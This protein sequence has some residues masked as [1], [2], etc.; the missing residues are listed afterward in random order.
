MEELSKSVFALVAAAVSVWTFL[1]PDAPGFASPEFARI[2]F[3]HFPCPIMLTG[4]IFTAVWFSYR[5]VVGPSHRLRHLSEGMSGAAG[6]FVRLLSGVD[7][8]AREVWDLRAIAAIELGLVFSVL[9]MFSGIL[10][11]KIQW[12]AWWNWDPRQ[13]SFLISMLFYGAYFAIRAAFPD[14]EKRAANSAAY[15]MATLPAQLFL[16]FVYPRIKESL[17]PSNTIMGGQLHGGYLWAMLS[18]MAVVGVLTVWLY[19]L[20]VRAGLLLLRESDDRLESLENPRRPA[21]GGVV[22][23]PVPVPAEGGA[24][25]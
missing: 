22:A 16:I 13:T 10:F 19:R 18:M 5:Y 3:W 11:S 25:R 7:T 1:V 8:P 21:G 20:R 4:L 2:F 6:R 9:T 14:P 12:G 23:R 17:H 15:L 24:D